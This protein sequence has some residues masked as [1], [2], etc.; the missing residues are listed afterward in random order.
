MR[1]IWIDTDA[2]TDDAMALIMALR[3]SD[4][5]V[6]G[7]ST[8]GGN[9]PLDKVV[10]NVLYICELCNANVP[11]HL[12]AAQPL[13][14][15][16][17][18]ADFIHG[19]DGLGD[20]GLSLKDRMSSSE[21]A[22]NSMIE[23][24]RAF[25]KELTVVNL[26]PLTNMAMVIRSAPE[27]LDLIDHTYVMGGLVDLPG[28]VTPLAEFNIWADPEAAQE[29]FTSGL[30]MTTI[31]WDTTMD[32]GW[33]SLDEWHGLQKLNTELATFAHDIQGVRMQWQKDN[34]HDLRLTWADPCAMAAIIDPSIV[35]ESADVSM[36]VLGG[37]DDAPQRGFI[38]ISNEPKITHV[39]R[40]DRARFR[41]MIHKYLSN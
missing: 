34:E 35:L 15:A 27:I 41:N 6:I 31:G 25:P 26:G 12:G 8:V 40:I 4:L 37:A 11:V 36:N 14:R 18:T 13:D 29:V 30:T 32:S 38:E 5:E 9:V 19:K 39:K 28:N 16:L 1:K 24:I 2:G 7:I 21:D 3:C 17:G 10:Q 33:L 20:I 22:V 23:A